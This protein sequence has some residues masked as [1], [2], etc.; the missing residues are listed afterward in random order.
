MLRSGSNRE[1][2]KEKFSIISAIKYGLSILD[3]EDIIWVPISIEEILR[4][5]GNI[6]LKK[7]GGLF[8][9]KNLKGSTKGVY[10]DD[11]LFMGMSCKDELEVYFY[12][13]EVKIG[14]NKS[15]I[16]S[17][18]EKQVL[19]TANLINEELSQR[20][21][22]F[23]KK[24][25][26]NFFIQLFLSNVHKLKSNNIWD[27]K[28][29]GLID[30]V[31][32]YLLNDEYLISH[33]LDSIIGKG[34]I[35]SFKNTCDTRTILKSDDVLKIEYPSEDGFEGIIK[36]V[37][38]INELILGEHNN[39]ASSQILL[40][41]YNISD[42][43][44]SDDNYGE[45]NDLN[46]EKDEIGSLTVEKEDCLEEDSFE[47]YPKDNTNFV[48]DYSENP[49][50]TDVYDNID[51]SKIRAYVGDIQHQGTKVYWEFGHSKLGNRHLFIQGGFWSRKNLFNAVFN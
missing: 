38:E 51:V 35:I 24:F 46:E 36:S 13:I 28:D 11:L 48:E 32:K 43:S 39:E 45:I 10:S 49:Q 9:V 30:E 41:N 14:E 8:S 3:N 15:G 29:Y 44:E 26:R 2:N 17:K 1:Q 33:K 37:S 7:E 5:A 50:I 22:D 25:Y 6:G 42:L 27:E 31:K 34:A 47:N 23:E 21:V 18:A 20:D 40:T 16:I 19:K 4:V 12:P